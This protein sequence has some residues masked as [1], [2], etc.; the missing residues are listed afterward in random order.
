MNPTI[1]EG[2][3]VYVNKAAYD[4]RVPLTRHRLAQW[5]NPKRG[6]VVVLFSPEDEIRLVKRVIAVPGDTLEMK[7]NSLR[8]NGQALD[9]GV[10][11]PSA[12]AGLAEAI[13][14]R[15]AFAEEDLAGKK[16]AVM[17]LP[18]ITGPLR[19]FE[20]IVLP[21]GQYFVMGDNR[22]LSKD[23]RSFGFVDRSRIVGQA[24]RV[25]VSFNK[26]DKCQPRW[27]RFFSR[28]N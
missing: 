5:D 1:L 17:E 6:D 14:S 19:N 4:L 9:Y 16:H 3:L 13:R 12:S 22:D 20:K 15:A 24:T 28:L 2:D 27:G 18:E 23:S 8:L 26:N 25:L 7:N 21:P 11:A 10:L